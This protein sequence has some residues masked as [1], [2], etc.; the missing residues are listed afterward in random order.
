M[1]GRFANPAPALRAPT[2][3]VRGF[4]RTPGDRPMGEDAAAGPRLSVLKFGSSVLSQPDDYV[5]AAAAIAVEAARN[6]KVVA[7]VSAMG[8]TTDTLLEAACAVTGEPPGTLLGAL[9]ATG[10]DASVALLALALASRGVP[11]VGLDTRKVPVLTRGAL[12]DAEPMFVD[13]GLVHAA[14]RKRAVVVFPGFVGED[15]SGVPSLLG[16]GGSDL[17][18]LFLGDMLAASEIRLVKDVGGIFPSDPSGREGL[19][20]YAELTWAEARQVG[21]GV[22][23]P[24]AID[25]AE[26][27]RIGFRVTG[28][29]GGAGT[30]VGES[31]EAADVA[32]AGPWTPPPFPETRRTPP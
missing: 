20:P 3:C 25:F 8:H 7:V 21:G 29:G 11:A 32:P 31:E 10:E 5:D 14:L 27:R 30:W 13:A 18:A 2:P 4:P 22:V 16:R 9:L 23:Q 24:K 1:T 28:L 26:R 6:R 15:V 12:D 17:T 19:A